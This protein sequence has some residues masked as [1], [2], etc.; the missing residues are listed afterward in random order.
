MTRAAPQAGERVVEVSSETLAKIFPGSGDG[1]QP[2][3]PLLRRWTTAARLR[4]RLLWTRSQFRF[5]HFRA[6][7][8]RWSTLRL[9]VKLLVVRLRNRRKLKR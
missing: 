2:P 8:C 6:I 7:R 5:G 3:P 1:P 4:L 9:R